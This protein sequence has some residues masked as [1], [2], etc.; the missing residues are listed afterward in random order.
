[1]ENPQG[2][3]R[4]RLLAALAL[5]VPAA[6]AAAWLLAR[7]APAADPVAAFLDRHWQRPIAPQG[8]PP[9]G[10]SAL[11]ASLDPRACGQCHVRQYQDWQGS[12]HRQAMTAGV[13][14]QLRLLPQDQ[15]N[16]CLDCHAPLAEQKAL[17]AL[18]QGWSS[19]PK[20][21][22]PAHVP[23]TL[24]HDGLVCAACHVR[25]HA[26]FGPPPR[27]GAPDANGPHGGFEVSAAFED[28]RF[29]AACHQFPEDGPRVAGKLHEDT[30]AQWRQSRHAAEGRQCQSCHMPDRQHRWPG[31]HSADMVRRALDVTLEATADGR[32]VAHL[33]NVGAGHYFPTYMVPKVEV[34]LWLATPDGQ[35]RRLAQETIGWEVNVELTG[36]RFDTRIPPGGSRR[37]EAVLPPSWPAGSELELRIRV[38]PREHYERTYRSV[39]EQADKLDAGTLRL[40]RQA[41]DEA[42][43]T[44]FEALR[45][46]RPLPPAGKTGG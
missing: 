11:E 18:A 12:L 29:C 26:R 17:V 35:A 7:P 16:E 4:R 41:Y 14:W 3:K 27:S 15:A 20:A 31:I 46:R 25:G 19:A 34:E 8:R 10:H 28:S 40:L 13:L 30:L 39:L 23:A 38:A 9:A 45:L 21:P 5:L 42:V 37:L 44:R 32:A 1:M 33:G 43:A 22:P 6:L 2:L 36:E 24:G